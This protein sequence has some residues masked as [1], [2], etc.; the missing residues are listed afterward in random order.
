[1]KERYFTNRPP[2]TPSD[3]R[4]HPRAP[5][6]PAPREDIETVPRSAIPSEASKQGASWSEAFDKAERRT[7]KILIYN[8]RR[9]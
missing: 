5:I 6:R 4:L 9:L 3:R 1:M 2:Y 8:R 7:W